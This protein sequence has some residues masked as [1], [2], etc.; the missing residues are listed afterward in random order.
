MTQ[1]ADPL[2]IL[3]SLRSH[4]VEYVL[5]GELAAAIHGG[6]P[7]TDVVEICVPDDQRNLARIAF[8]LQHVMAKVMP[9]ASGEAHRASFNTRFGRLDCL[10]DAPGFAAL[11]TNASD[12]DLGDDIVA[13]VASLQD[14]ARLKEG[15]ADLPGAVRM[16][17][18]AA[19]KDIPRRELDLPEDHEP[20]AEGRFARLMQRLEGVDEFL[21]DVNRGDRALRRGKG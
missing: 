13:R 20:P 6:P 4:G 11:E 15:S 10:E 19:A 14:L 16:T 3:A 1:P 9:S 7:S 17:A 21:T 12:V 2:R 18:L 8:V 5:V